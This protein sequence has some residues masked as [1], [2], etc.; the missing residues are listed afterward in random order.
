MYLDNPE[1]CCYDYATG[2]LYLRHPLEG[3]RLR[4]HPWTGRCRMEVLRAGQWTQER[5]PM[6]DIPLFAHDMP[7]NAPAWPFFADLPA[8]VGAY[9][10]RYPCDQLTLLRLCALS[11][12]TRR[13]AGLH[14]NL[15]WYIA[16]RLLHHH[17]GGSELDAAL[18][19]ALDTPKGLESLLIMQG[20]PCEAWVLD[21]LHSLGPAQLSMP[22][23]RESV[24]TLLDCYQALS[25]Y[26]AGKPMDWGW[27]NRQA[28]GQSCPCVWGRLK[29][30]P[31]LTVEE[32]PD[33]PPA[34]QPQN[35]SGQ[36]GR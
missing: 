20:A 3:W 25:G 8:E 32:S 29:T 1:F 36:H 7:H 11:P 18:T 27:L 26:F 17:P 5:L 6:W 13:L 14:P 28:R 23:A 34:P 12:A 9:I 33:A 30:L 10:L 2:L 15:L 22:H 19:A 31:H 4:M 21:L 16:P 24:A 35:W